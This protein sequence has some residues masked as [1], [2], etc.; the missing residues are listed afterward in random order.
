VA[1][2]CVNGI[3]LVIGVGDGAKPLIDHCNK[4]NLKSYW[5]SSAYDALQ[6]LKNN[7]IKLPVA[8]RITILIKGSRS[9]HMERVV[10]GLQS[11]DVNCQLSSCALT[12]NCQQCEFL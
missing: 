2:S 3:S 8:E 12:V 4:N 1:D 6:V 5:C 10:L 11:K 7:L 9:V